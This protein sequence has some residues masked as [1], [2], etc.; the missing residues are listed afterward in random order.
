MAR[1][2]GIGIATLDIVNTVAH[3]PAEDEEIR[4]VSQR[5]C[6]GGNCANTLTVLRQWGQD[7]TFAGVL[8]DGPDGQFIAQQLEQQGINIDYCCTIAGKTPTSYIA[9]SRTTSTRTIIHYRD[10]PE[11]SFT[12]FAKIELSAFDWVHFE[13]RNVPDTARMLALIRKRFPSLPRSVEIEKPR[14]GIE[15]LF[16]GATLLLFS[17]HYAS[18]H[19]YFDAEVFLRTLHPNL[20]HIDKV[21]AWG[22]D[23]AYAISQDGQLYHAPACAPVQIVDT[24]G[25]GDTFNAGLI[26]ACLRRLPLSQSLTFACQVAGRKCG[27]SGFNNLKRCNTPE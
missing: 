21:C 25:A 16:A 26:D 24:L 15:T 27:Q 23:G 2:L 17:R 3:Y 10:L 5:R 8:A 7:C 4:A 13:G 12:D 19:G 11:F 6:V 20:P 14:P 1:I 18:Y 22:E 9:L